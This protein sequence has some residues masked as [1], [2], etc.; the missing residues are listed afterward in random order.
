MIKDKNLTEHFIC[1]I[2]RQ[3]FDM[4]KLDQNGDAI[5]KVVIVG[6]DNS[7]KKGWTFDGLRLLET[8]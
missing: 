8:N 5:V 6:K 4:N 2:K 7:W 1:D 3:D